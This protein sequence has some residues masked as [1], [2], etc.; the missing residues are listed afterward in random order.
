[1]AD[2]LPRRDLIT[3]MAAD[4][5]GVP[6]VVGV[7]LGGS[8]ARGTHLPD[9]D[10]DLG[11]YYRGALD[12]DALAALARRWTGSAVEIAGPG[13]WG[14]WVNGGAWLG[15]GGQAVD[16]I[17]RDLDRVAAQ[18][19][20]ARAG[21][22]A[23]HSQTGHPFGFLDV[24]YAGELAT[25][26]VL[27]DPTGELNRLRAEL[28]DYPDALREAMVRTGLWQAGFL[29]QVAGKGVPRGDVNY[30]ALCLSSALTWCAHAWHAHVGA[31]VTNEKDLVPHVARLGVETAGFSDAAAA[32]L[33]MLAPDEDALAA[34]RDAVAAVVRDTESQLGAA[35]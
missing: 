31:W 25:G 29:V 28:T 20:R 4:L 11:L 27:A 7:L 32:A 5:A 14:P 19:E 12:V 18:C 9:S 17:L 13:A 21:Q 8:R 34:A 3:R 30:L 33:G 23:F 15:V 22:F 2:E 35:G 10:V 16:W 1:M 6:G 26:V 24:S